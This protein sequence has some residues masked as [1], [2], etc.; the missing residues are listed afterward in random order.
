[1][2]EPPFE[3]LGNDA[4]S[5]PTLVVDALTVPSEYRFAA[6]TT[7]EALLL[8][9]LSDVEKGTRIVFRAGYV[10]NLIL[11]LD[12]GCVNIPAN[13]SGCICNNTCVLRYRHTDRCTCWIY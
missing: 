8:R 2:L 9:H 5:G 1:M 12:I 11:V 13:A 7:P 3:T 10:I 6:V 4:P